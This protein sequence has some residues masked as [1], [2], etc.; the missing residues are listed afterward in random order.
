MP[1]SSGALE[2]AHKRTLQI[3]LVSVA[4]CVKRDISF[5]LVVR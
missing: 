3:P 1:Q 5:Q 4:D 2:S